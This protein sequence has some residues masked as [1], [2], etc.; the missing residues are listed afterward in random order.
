MMSDV[1]ATLDELY[2]LLYQIAGERTAH[3]PGLFEDALQEA[4]IAAWLRLDE[5]KS[6]GIAVHNAK[7]AVVDLLRGGRMTGS[8]QAG[9]PIGAHHR[10]L[11]LVVPGGSDSDEYLIEP[12]DPAATD[13]FD[14]VDSIDVLRGLLE[15]L[16]DDQRS[17]V[18]SRLAGATTR[19]IASEQGVSHQAI[20][21]RL[22]RV[23]EALDL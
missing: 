5:G 16:S 17:L 20:S 8:Q 9:I 14:E 2:Y 7:Q 18:L 19:E 15:P 4:L 21:L 13:A 11:P 22:K 10:A 12:A 6:I 23:R 1:E 3:R